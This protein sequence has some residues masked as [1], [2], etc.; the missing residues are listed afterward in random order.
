[1]RLINIFPLTT[2]KICTKNSDYKHCLLA[3]L[4]YKIKEL[5]NKYDDCN[6]RFWGHFNWFKK[7]SGGKSCPS[8]PNCASP[9]LRPD[10]EYIAIF[11]KNDKRLENVH[12]WDCEPKK[13][14]FL[15]E[16]DRN[17]YIITPDEY[18]KYTLQTW[19]IPPVNDHNY[20]H[21][22]RFPEELPYRLIK[23]FTYPTDVVLDTFCGS[24]TTCAVAK[25]LKRNFI[26]IDIVPAYCKLS[27]ER[28][29]AIE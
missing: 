15:S 9:V 29:N 13:D 4:I 28:C 27:Q 14:S 20:R 10:S 1:M 7:N 26:G 19:E 16:S 8:S 17:K 11:V 24:G 25:K 2:N 18:D 12:G 5:N 21:P 23:L 3:D 6:L 22:A